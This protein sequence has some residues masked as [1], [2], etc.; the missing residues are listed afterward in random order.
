MKY[1]NRTKAEARGWTWNQLSSRLPKRK[2]ER[3][4]SRIFTLIGET[5]E[6]FTAGIHKGFSP[7]NIIGVDLKETSVKRW[8]QAGGF[9]VQGPLDLVVIA[10][11]ISPSGV[12]C[13]FCGGMTKSNFNTFWNCFMYLNRPGAIILNMLRGRDDIKNMLDTFDGNGFCSA[14]GLD[15]KRRCHVIYAKLL[16]DSF[17][18]DLEIQEI[19]GTGLGGFLLFAVLISRRLD[20]SFYSYKSADSRQYFDMIAMSMPQFDDGAGP[21]AL[22]SSTKERVRER[23]QSVDMRD[24]RRRMAALEAVR[25]MAIKKNRGRMFRST[26]Y[27]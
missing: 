3:Q 25:T 2:I 24:T 17:M 7:F 14:L 21:R 5:T 22:D 11:R 4:D 9:A 16:W 20:P 19:T 1:D 27:T 23:I 26:D 12:I 15:P 6:D 13:D 10:S 18:F 8:R